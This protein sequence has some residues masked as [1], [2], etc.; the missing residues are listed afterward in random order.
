VSGPDVLVGVDDRAPATAGHG[1]RHDLAPERPAS[2]AAATAR[3][4][5]RT[6]YSVLLL[7]RDGSVLAG[8]GS[9]AVSSIPPGTGW[10]IPPAVTRPRASASCSMPAGAGRA[11]PPLAVRVERRPFDIDSAPPAI[12]TSD[13]PGG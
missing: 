6:A 1:H 5:D 7:A 11:A 4:C 12:T 10:L 2:R 3:W 13:A 9:P 8:A